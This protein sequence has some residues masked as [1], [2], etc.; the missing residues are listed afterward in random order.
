LLEA[1]VNQGIKGV[2]LGAFSMATVRHLLIGLASSSALYSGFASALGLGEITL[3]SALSQ[4]LKAEI[5]LLNAG[6]LND[7]DLRVGLAPAAVYA[8]AGVDRLM[9]LNDL[10]FTPVF[11]GQS[12]VIRVMSNQA[13]SE[14]Y[15]NF[16]IEVQRP[17]GVLYREY[18][19]LLDPPGSSAYQ[20]VSAVQTVSA[21]QSVTPAP[22]VARAPV[23]MPKAEMGKG[24]DVVSGDSLWKIAKRYAP[25]TAAVPS[26][27]ND[28][29]AL[30][31]QAFVGGDMNRLRAGVQLRLPDRAEVPNAVA[32][33]VNTVAAA[34]APAP[35][36]AASPA[37]SAESNEVDAAVTADA[38]QTPAVPVEQVLTEQAAL[39]EQ[40]LVG[41]AE[42]TQKLQQNLDSLAVQVQQLQDQMTARDQQIALL[43]AELAERETQPAAA[44]SAPMPAVQAPIAEQGTNWF[45]GAAGLLALVMAGVLALLWRKNRNPKPTAA[46]VQNAPLAQGKTAAVAPAFVRAAPAATTVTAAE[47]VAVPAPEADVLQSANVYMAYGHYKEAAVALR[48][49][50]ADEPQRGDVGFRYLEVLAKLGDAQG[51]LAIEPEVRATGFNPARLDELKASHAQ[52]FVEPPVG[53]LSDVVLNERETV[54]APVAQPEG[55]LNLDDFTLNADWDAVNPFA[56]VTANK[57]QPVQETA[58]IFDLAD[59]RDARSPFAQS[60]LVEEA[61]HGSWKDELSAELLDLDLNLQDDEFEPSAK[62]NLAKLN[63]AHAFIDQGNLVGACQ[64]LNEIILE[65]DEVEQKEAR[66]LLAKIA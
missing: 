37:L 5:K 53:L 54:D 52:L 65:G 24:Y 39:V 40:E 17:T 66:D 42:Q 38:P 2:S 15:L 6:E 45:T 46:L 31:P 23:V 22:Q 11:N 58:E 64:V 20:S 10:R 56:P 21:A 1:S 60:M 18:T 26:L 36:P 48:K 47:R 25:S 14:P 41:Q 29:H 27:M 33:V 57:Q 7:S 3:Q 35:A 34:P 63:I 50:W 61:G 43:Q 32:D 55:Q 16:I 8:R 49:A 13:V 30:N 59:S 44:P 51:Y 19:V 4:P 62:G 28:I 12:S 9:F